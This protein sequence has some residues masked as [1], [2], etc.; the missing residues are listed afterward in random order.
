[1][2]KWSGK[3]IGGRTYTATDGSTRWI[4]RKTVVGVAHNVTLDV[5]SEAQALAELA[6]FRRNPAVYRTASQERQ[7]EAQQ[8]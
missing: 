4:I 3:W 2:T 7:D 5:R 8:A 1:M 6:A